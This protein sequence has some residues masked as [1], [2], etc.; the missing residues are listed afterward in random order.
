MRKKGCHVIFVS[1]III[2][3]R[4]MT[5]FMPVNFYNE[6]YPIEPIN[7]LYKLLSVS[8]KER[9]SSPY[10]PINSLYKLLSVS[11]A[12]VGGQRHISL[13]IFGIYVLSV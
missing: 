11:Y 4:E 8:Y 2:K 3:K 1:P 13:M 6:C 9:H 12:V 7:S 10:E 5:K